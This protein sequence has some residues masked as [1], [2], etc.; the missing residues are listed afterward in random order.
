MVKINFSLTKKVIDLQDVGGI[1]FS[2][3]N[4]KL[5]L[6]MI[7]LSY[8]PEWFV[9]QEFEDQ[10]K[11]AEAEVRTLNNEQRKLAK[12]KKNYSQYE[13]KF[14]ALRDQQNRLNEKLKIVKTI[15]TTKK[16][17]E[18][19]LHYVA[20]NMP[21]N[22]WVYELKIEQNVFELKGRSRDYKSVGLFIQSLK[23]SIFFSNTLKLDSSKTVEISENKRVEEF[24]LKGNIVRFN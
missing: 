22:L 14:E 17:P 10:L 24:V 13:D 15:I 21:K 2:N 3:L 1:N 19:L 6:V 5:T 12:K 4:V 18:E 9:Y 16:N 11:S 23:N 7:L 20:K 8:V